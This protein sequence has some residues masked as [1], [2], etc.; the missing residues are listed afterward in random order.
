MRATRRRLFSFLVNTAIR[1][2]RDAMGRSEL[3]D[4]ARGMSF[5]TD[6]GRLGVRMTAFLRDRLRRT[7]LR[8][9]SAR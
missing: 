4:R 5:E 1:S 9:R 6:M 8:L 3:K 7:W 2:S